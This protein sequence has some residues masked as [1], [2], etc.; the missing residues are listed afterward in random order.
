MQTC[1]KCKS[2]NI[3]S[4]EYWYDNPERYDGISEYMCKDCEYR[5][6]RWTGKELKSGYI[7]PRLGRGGKPVKRSKK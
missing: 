1:P 7:E 2:K 6:G 3:I 4:C 5:Q